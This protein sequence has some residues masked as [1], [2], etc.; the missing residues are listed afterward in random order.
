MG[1]P[2][3]GK[4]TLRLQG[5]VKKLDPEV[6][7]MEEHAKAVEAMEAK[8]KA[9]VEAK[10]KLAE[11]KEGVEKDLKALADKAKEGMDAGAA[12]IGGVVHVEDDDLEAWAI[13]MLEMLT[14]GHQEIC[15]RIQK[16]G[17]GSCSR[18]S[19][20][21]GCNLCHF[22]KAVR[23]WRKEETKGEFGEGLQGKRTRQGEGSW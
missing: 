11:A 3:A 15:R 8:G 5:I 23:Y 12:E 22:A 9:D 17:L 10:A 21:A 7:K 13:G 4:V 19:F 18:C 14:P 20:G 16:E 2:D 6:N 1:W